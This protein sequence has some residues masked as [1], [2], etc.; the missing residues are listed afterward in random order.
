MRSSRVEKMHFASALGV[1]DWL[2]A[3]LHRTLE[4]VDRLAVEPGLRAYP[5]LPEAVAELQR[6]AGL[7]QNGRERS[8]LQKR[9]ACPPGLKIGWPLVPPT[10][11]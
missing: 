11:F 2:L 9:A 10:I 8:M 4:L 7:S 1:S 5:H 3:S 6:A